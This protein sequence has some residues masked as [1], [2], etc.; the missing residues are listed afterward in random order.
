M[1]GPVPKAGRS[2]GCGGSAWQQRDAAKERRGSIWIHC[3]A[4]G[5]A[6]AQN[7]LARW[8]GSLRPR[9]DLFGLVLRLPGAAP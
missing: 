2:R 9:A 8:E 7:S 1:A 4:A 6:R 5:K 3:V